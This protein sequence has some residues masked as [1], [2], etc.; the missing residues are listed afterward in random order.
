MSTPSPPPLCECLRD[1]GK[2]LHSPFEFTPMLTL[3]LS[4]LP[5]V[6]GSDLPDHRRLS[7]LRY[8]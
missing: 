8:C 1:I 4:C 7:S 6:K 2:E 5:V 3:L